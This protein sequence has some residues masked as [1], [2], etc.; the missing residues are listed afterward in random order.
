MGDKREKIISK[1]KGM[2]GYLNKKKKEIIEA[3]NSD[4]PRSFLAYKIS[5]DIEKL[6]MKLKNLYEEGKKK[7]RQLIKRKRSEDKNQ[8][9]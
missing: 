4:Y 7:T 5:Q 8:K 6:N 9:I 1:I 2:I 3:I